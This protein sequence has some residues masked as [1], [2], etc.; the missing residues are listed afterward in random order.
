MDSV[1]NP[2]SIQIS[3]AQKDKEEGASEIFRSALTAKELS[4]SSNYQKAISAFLRYEQDANAPLSWEQLLFS[5]WL[6]GYS[7]PTANHYLTLL[8]TLANR[9]QEK[10]PLPAAQAT[11]IK[12]Y[13]R[14]LPSANRDESITPQ[15]FNRL[16]ALTSSAVTLPEEESLY[17]DLLILALLNPAVPF[18]QMPRLK[19]TDA[20][21]L[22]PESRAIIER[23]ISPSR[24]YIFPLGQSNSTPAQLSRRINHHITVLLRR[25]DIPV[26][27]TL[28]ATIAAYRAYALLQIGIGPME[29]LASVADS[30]DATLMPLTPLISGADHNIKEQRSPVSD[31]VLTSLANLLGGPGPQWFAMK[32][33]P[34]VKYDA[35]QSKLK[36]MSATMQVPALYYPCEE[37]AERIGRRLIFKDRPFIRDIVF[38]RA[39]LQEI[40]PLFQQIGSLAWCYKHNDG[41]YASI[42]LAAMERFQRTIGQFTSDIEIAPAGQLPFGPGDKVRVIGGLFAGMEGEYVGA[43]ETAAGTIYRVSL[44]GSLLAIEWRL[45]DPRLLQKS[46]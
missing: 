16:L 24:Q 23:H 37:I 32:L 1:I 29:A 36:E 30:V 31:S 14:S 6:D 4:P 34:S 44:F 20:E 11:E 46:E 26:G 25:R 27:A 35:L 21:S 10:S 43:K 40:R 18:A 2:D 3:D 5:L 45:T 7:L 8:T 15:S 38:F 39:R 19:R 28:S 33:R 22:S 42:P 41:T 12:A 9:L 17:A 13:L